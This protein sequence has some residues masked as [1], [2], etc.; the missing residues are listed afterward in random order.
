[1]QVFKKNYQTI[2]GLVGSSERFRRTGETFKKGNPS[3]N[4]RFLGEGEGLT[5][6]AL[7][8]VKN[9]RCRQ[10]E[11]RVSLNHFAGTAKALFCKDSRGIK[12][13]YPDGYTENRRLKNTL[14]RKRT[15]GSGGRI[16]EMDEGSCI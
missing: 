13:V 6:L 2:M 15:L 16:L 3:V 14:N 7:A 9:K 1:M 5:T 11:L 4:I 10:F 8:P 12:S